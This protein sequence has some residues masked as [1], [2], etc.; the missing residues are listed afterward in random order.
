MENSA[1]QVAQDTRELHLLQHIKSDQSYIYVFVF[2]YYRDHSVRV[3]KLTNPVSISETLDYDDLINNVNRCKSAREPAIYYREGITGNDAGDSIIDKAY[4]EP[5]SFM[6]VACGDVDIQTIEV[7]IQGYDE[8]EGVGILDSNV[9]PPYAITATKFE[10]KTSGGYVF[11]T[12]C[13]LFGHGDRGHPTMAVGVEKKNRN[14]FGR[15][16]P[17]YVAANYKRRNFWAKKDWWFPTEGQMVEQFIKQQS[18]PYVTADNVMIAP[19][20]REIRHHAHY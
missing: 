12:Y 9:T 8:I 2:L 20:V 17:M 15:M 13:G 1:R 3:W 18:I 5:V 10:R 14:A 16:H 4:C 11:Y 7:N 19:C 6:I